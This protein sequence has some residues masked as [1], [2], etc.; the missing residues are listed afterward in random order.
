MRGAAKRSPDVGAQMSEPALSRENA[1]VV[2]RQADAVN[3]QDLDG[4]LACLAGDVEWEEDPAGFP[5][6]RSVYRGPAE[7]REWFEDVV[8]ELWAD[9]RFEREEIEQLPDGRV[10]VG[11]VFVTRGQ[12]SGVETK[13]RFW[14]V[15]QFREGQIARR[16]VFLDRADALG[17]AGLAE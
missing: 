13:L 7:V 8:L 14:Q 17:A 11:G 5:G 12:G 16:R 15:F 10:F 3:R 4:F 2:M 1:E 9:P 6:L